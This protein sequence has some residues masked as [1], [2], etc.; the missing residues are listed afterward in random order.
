M[1]MR[2][3]MSAEAVPVALRE[4]HTATP[5]PKVDADADTAAA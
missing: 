3:D 2:N 4:A 1:S 5:A